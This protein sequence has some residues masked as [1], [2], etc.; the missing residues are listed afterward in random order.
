[1]KKDIG[2]LIGIALNL[3]TAFGNIF[4]FIVLILLINEHGRS[5]HFLVRKTEI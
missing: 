4:V 3:S 1:V 2:I 5:F